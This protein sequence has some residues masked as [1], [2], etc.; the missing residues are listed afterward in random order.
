MNKLPLALF[1]ILSC[2]MAMQ[3][4]VVM[5]GIFTDNMVLQRNVLIPVWGWAKPKEKIEVR[6]NNQVKTVKADKS[7]KWTLK[8]DAEKAGGPYELTVKAKNTIQIKNVL[9]G[10]VWLCSGQSNMELTVGQS[11]NAQKEIASANY[12]LI[13]HIK[14]PH[15]ISSMPESD[16]HPYGWE[17][18]D[19]TTVADFTGIGY[20]FAKEIYNELKVPV[21]LI[22]SSWGGTNIETWISR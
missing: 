17:V 4:Q 8:L 12:P 1:V 9:V 20:F 14:I 11:M 22:N 2:S 3:A 13:R 21:G 6:F 7:G 18:C 5:P 19:S 16:F 10:E 15:T